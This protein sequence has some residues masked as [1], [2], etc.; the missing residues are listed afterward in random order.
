MKVDYTQVIR[1]SPEE[2]KQITNKQDKVVNF[3]KLQSL[4]LLKTGKIKTITNERYFFRS[5]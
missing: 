4:Y 2:L 5:P 3:Q 1:E